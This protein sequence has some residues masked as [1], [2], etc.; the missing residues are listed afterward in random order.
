MRTLVL[1]LVIVLGLA[2]CA[3]VDP[4]STAAP[5][6][7]DAP[8]ASAT[9][10]PDAPVDSGAP[11]DRACDELISLQ[12]IYD[13]N[14]NFVLETEVDAPTGSLA[15]EVAAAN[16]AFCRWVNQSSGE[17]IDLGVVN[18][19]PDGLAARAAELASSSVPAPNFAGEGYFVVTDG[20]GVAAAISA[21]YW[22]V[23]VSPVFLEAGDAEPLM[24]SV[25]SALR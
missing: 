9:A 1:P 22:V 3:V 23:L 5:A 4:M 15:A 17:T 14:S 10:T 24:L 8:S 6:V 25:L 19:G 18:P 20:A 21:P 7:P 11:V 13:Y 16:G 12:T 2:G